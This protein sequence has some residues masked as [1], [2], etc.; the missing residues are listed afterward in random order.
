MDGHELQTVRQWALQRIHQTR[1][2]G[3][4][5]RHD[6]ADNIKAIEQLVAG[7]PHYTFGIRG[8]QRY[9]KSEV[10]D[11]IAS[12]TGCSR[13]FAYRQGAG[14]IS[15]EA[16]LSGLEAA[17]K[18]IL[19]EAKK[20]GRFIVGT[21]HPGSLLAFYI[22]LIRLIRE[23]GGE[24]IEVAQ[25]AHIPPN[26][27][28][29]YV[30]GVA[31]IS[32]RASLWHTHDVKPMEEI[33]RANGG[34]DLAIVDHGFAG[35]AINAGIPAITIIDTNDPAPAVAKKMGARLT[36]IPMD[37]NRLPDDYLPLV[38][39]VRELASL[40]RVPAASVEAVIRPEVALRFSDAERL[41]RERTNGMGAIE[42]LVQDFAEAYRDQ[43]MQTRL[44]GD[45][46]DER[47]EDNYAV[48]AAYGLLR[49]ALDRFILEE[50]HYR[51]LDLSPEE[52]AW[53]FRRYTDTS[54]GAAGAVRSRP[55]AR[56]RRPPLQRK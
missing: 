40:Q 8:L 15:P 27:E 37:D 19:E 16:T 1:V 42:Q 2:A 13:D 53:Y 11:A 21:G 3:R 7:N 48:V 34:A 20:H 23:W 38:S 32:D 43:L 35:G 25:G 44:R 26:F 51:H 9:S 47:P 55:P 33:L 45:G 12:V 22:E 14:Y 52:T 41:V 28:L 24:I 31:V 5:T 50:M 56:E 39:T 49:K 10:L 29:A 46:R 36:I 18:V 17:T 6:R 54:V 4:G 30:E